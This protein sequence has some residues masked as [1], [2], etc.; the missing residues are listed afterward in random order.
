MEN[1]PF[2]GKNILKEIFIK[3][4]VKCFGK[5]YEGGL[6]RIWLMMNFGY[7]GYLLKILLKITMLAYIF[8][9]ICVMVIVETVL[10]FIFEWCFWDVVLIFCWMMGWK[11]CFEMLFWNL[12]WMMFLN[13]GFYEI[14]MKWWWKC[15]GGA[16]LCDDRKMG[17]AYPN[18]MKFSLPS[19]E[20]A[21]AAWTAKPKSISFKS[22]Q[23]APPALVSQSW[24]EHE[25]HVSPRCSTSLIMNTL[26]Q[27][28]QQ[29]H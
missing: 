10:K 20:K 29:L 12:G 11:V 14:V 15:R 8:K 16:G 22:S 21:S 13:D 17:K 5:F 6:A 4:Y 18:C 1:P 7:V 25:V 28:L 26:C 19:L 24:R 27:R 3:C 23:S 9:M 2:Q